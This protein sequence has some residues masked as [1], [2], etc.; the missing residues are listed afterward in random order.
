M[1]IC[2][3]EDDEN[4]RELICYTLKTAG[5]IVHS[6]PSAEEFLGAPEQHPQLMIVDIMLPGMDGISLLK[7]LREDKR[8]NTPFIFLTAR[9]TEMDKVKGLN[10]GADDYIT[11]PFGV[12][13]LIARVQAVLR[14]TSQ[15]SDAK[16]KEMRRGKLVLE[17]ATRKVRVDN[18]EIELT[19]KEFEM[20]HYFMQNEGIVLTRE[21]LL[22][23]IW[24]IDADIETRTVDMH[25]KTLRKKLGPCKEYIQTVRG[26]GYRF[27]AEK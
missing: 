27:E 7:K 25:V 18:S 19:F 24:G 11:K 3:I 9:V 26:V 6:Y 17:G 5:Y 4:V 12:L 8:V 2:V 1:Y 16:E 13:E 23:E 22:G 21:M 10:L 15:K 20:L 14:R